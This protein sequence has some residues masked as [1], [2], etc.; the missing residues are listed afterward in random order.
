MAEAE[1]RTDD[2]AT[3]ADIARKFRISTRTVWRR[4]R[5]KKL[6]E[7]VMLFGDLPRWPWRVVLAAAGAQLESGYDDPDEA[8]ARGD[9]E[10]RQDRSAH[11]GRRKR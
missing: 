8:L 9:H 7:P 11:A 10:R 4:V 6:P 3:A 1:L 2:Y 5:A